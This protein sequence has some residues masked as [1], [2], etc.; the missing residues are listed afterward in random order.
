MTRRKSITE[1]KQLVHQIFLVTQC[2]YQHAGMTLLMAT[3]REKVDVKRITCPE[4]IQATPVSYGNRLVVVPVPRNEPRVA[5]RAEMYLWRQE[6]LQ[7]SGDIP[8]LPC[9]ILGD[10]RGKGGYRSLP[11]QTPVEVL[12][13]V[14]TEV[15]LH[16]D[17]SVKLRRIALQSRVCRVL[18]PLQEEI[19]AGTLA[20]ETVVDMAKRLNITPRGVFSGRTALMNK[21]GLKNRLSLMA[22]KPEIT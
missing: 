6:L 8:I 16:P 5:A 10:P 7:L 22:L 12:R 3:A 4:D 20:G 1:S 15:L 9:V 17:K 2:R 19:L 14:L 13:D 21:L 11:E 18:S